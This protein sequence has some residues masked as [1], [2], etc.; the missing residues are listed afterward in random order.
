MNAAT[1][2]A[3]LQHIVDRMFDGRQESLA[4]AC[5]MSKGRI[6][7]LLNPKHAFGERAARLLEDKLGL[8]QQ[9]LDRPVVNHT[10]PSEGDPPWSVSQ[11]SRHLPPSV[12]APLLDSGSIMA[13]NVPSPFF[14]TRLEDDSAAPDYP[15]GTEILWHT[16]REPRPGRVVLVRDKHQAVHV[17]RY[18]QGREP[19][20]WTAAA[21]NGDFASLDSVDDGLAILAVFKGQM[22]PDD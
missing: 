6:S 1:R 14:R 10:L 22:E 3:N 12:S 2:R 8:Q 19:G 9:E 20:R 11:D 4:Q 18:R 7:Q 13:G 15:R 5:K 21:I 17:R 16:T